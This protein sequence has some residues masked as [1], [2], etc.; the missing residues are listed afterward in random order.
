MKIALINEGR[1]P[2]YGGGQ[3]HVDKLSQI[4]IQDY[5][6]QVD[7][8]T[9]KIKT[10]EGEIFDQ[11]EVNQYGLQIN[12]VGPTSIF[13]NGYYRVMWLLT[14]T[15]ALFQKAK[16][17]KYDIL[18]AHAMLPGI[19]AKI[20][21]FLL[22]IPVV[23]TVHGTMFMDS[24]RKGFSY[25]IEKLMTCG[26][27][28]NLEISVSSNIL[29]YQNR[30][31]NI[32]IIY[33]GVDLKVLDSI[34]TSG[35]YSKRTFITVARMD[36]QK[37][38]QIILDAIVKIGKEF[39]VKKNIQFLR[40]GDGLKEQEL[41]G[42]IQKHDLWDIV[43]LKGRLNFEETISEYKK[44][45]LF[46]LP[47]LGEGQP[48][49]VLEAMGCGLPVLA[50]NV[51]DNSFFIKNDL[52]GE[53]FEPGNVEEVVRVLRKYG[54][55]HSETL[56]KMWYQGKKWVQNYS[57]EECVKKVVEGYTEILD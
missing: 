31:K 9:R 34:K 14:V 40:I 12:R 27:R 33:N 25:L 13:F 16:K 48:L 10:P 52:N 24:G 55:L 4:L 50:T 38:H 49:T 30:N 19:P 51:G 53:L 39:F 22:N 56:E 46:L 54:E 36:W 23:Y 35:K 7:L 5:G 18:H 42:F 45:Q 21:G 37:N 47:S 6:F 28:Y 20:V 11:N 44:S 41:R 57:R 1:L 29:R 15:V 32:K 26:I 43:I 2:I 3:I 17:E 8:F